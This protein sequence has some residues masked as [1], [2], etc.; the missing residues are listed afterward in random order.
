MD[1]MGLIQVKSAQ[2]VTDDVMQEQKDRIDEEQR[3]TAQIITSLSADIDSKWEDAKRSKQNVEDVMLSSIRQKS[4]VYDPSK[5]A[6]ITAAKQPDIFMNITAT[7][8][9][10]G[11]AWVKDI[12]FQNF[13]RI[14]AV[15]PTPIPELPDHIVNQIQTSVVQ[16]YVKLAIEQAAQTGQ[17][18][19]AADLKAM[20]IEHSQE[21]EELVHKKTVEISK[22]MSLKVEDKIDDDWIQ[23][24]FYPAL[25]NVIDD[26]V[27]LKAGIV[28]GPI[29]RKEKTK[30]MEMGQDGKL[31]RII[32]D[33]IVP[34][35]E[36]RSPFNIYP[37]PR[38]TSIDSGYL[39]DVIA[40]KPRALYNL[41]GVDGYSEKEIRNVLREFREGT[42]TNNWLQLSD[43]AKDGMGENSN[44][45]ASGYKEESIYCLEL[46]ADISGG[47]L[48]EWGM[49]GITDE[50]AE[51]SCCTWKIGNHV[52]KAMLNYDKLGKKPYSK[53]SFQVVN[54]SFWGKGIPEII[55]DCQ[56]VCNACARSILANVGLGAIPMFGINVD[57]LEPN[58]STEVIPGKKWLFTDEQMASNIPPIIFYQPV[59][60]TEKLM[61]VYNE[62]S[63]I[64][65][66]HS[67]VPAWAHGNSQVGGAGS[68]AAGLSSLITQASR[69]IKDVIRNIDNDIISL[70]AESHYDYLLDNFDVFGLLGDYKIRAKGSEALLAKEQQATRKLEFLNYTA[71]PVDMQILGIEN[72]RKMLFD[73]ARNFGVEL[74]E[75]EL[76]PAQPQQMPGQV[77]PEQPQTLDAAGNP[78]QGVETNIANTKRPRLPAGG[79]Q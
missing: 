79:A 53:T 51:Y 7:K 34:C 52:I 57:R 22:K 2:E 78:A 35:Y 6:E 56:R 33:R 75:S 4:G 61:N 18:I 13:G 59:M 25:E 47:L 14:F 26:I 31:K 9:R 30:I 29:F 12:I 44:D 8:C 74:D 65:D 28:K 49:K 62:F 40:V 41:I 43:S 20:I 39:F 77:P 70:R 67:G 66:E 37:S 1:N 55:A 58:A 45:D 68:T 11:V 19:P 72:R 69:G 42:L 17:V 27:T 76:Q 36:R 32:V 10:N 21:M 63:R 3:S 38:S 5:L 16:G 46:W 71:N 50:D 54:D 24:G 64:A 60:V 23:Y 15:D 48:K 73:M